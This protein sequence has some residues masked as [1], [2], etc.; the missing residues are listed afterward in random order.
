MLGHVIRGKSNIVSGHKLF[1]DASEN[2]TTITISVTLLCNIAYFQCY[3]KDGKF[4][5]EYLLMCW[6]W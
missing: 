3:E 4:L 1:P 2:F 5:H 6:M